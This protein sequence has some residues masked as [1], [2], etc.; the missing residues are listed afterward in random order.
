MVKKKWIVIE[1]KSVTFGFRG[2]K[3]VSGFGKERAFVEKRR[4]VFERKTR[5]VE[6]TTRISRRI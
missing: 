1:K 6:N 4:L 5:V 2:G 3:K